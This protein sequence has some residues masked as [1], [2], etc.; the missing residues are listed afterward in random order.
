MDFS[1]VYAA[2]TA[3]SLYKTYLPANAPASYMMDLQRALKI[4]GFMDISQ[5]QL[6][7]NSETPVVQLQATKPDFTNG[8]SV[9]I[10]GRLKQKKS[11][12]PKREEE[13]DDLIDEDTLLDE[14]EMAQRPTK[15]SL[16]RKLDT[17]FKEK[18]SVY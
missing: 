16:Q 10:I 1:D 6:S 18:M 3:G 9:S 5:S 7:E 11:T 4:A 8:A 13:N 14:T 17:L 12:I 2:M 15:D